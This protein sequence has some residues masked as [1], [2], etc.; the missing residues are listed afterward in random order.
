M[1]VRLLFPLTRTS[2]RVPFDNQCFSLSADSQ[3]GETDCW[4]LD[5]P[6][7]TCQNAVQEPG[8]C[9]PRCVEANPCSNPLLLQAGGRDSSRD[10]CMYM[11]ALY[12]HGDSWVLESD[13]CTSCECKVSWK[14][15][16]IACGDLRVLKIDRAQ[17]ASCGVAC[18]DLRV[19]KIGG[20]PIA[21]CGVACGD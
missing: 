7:L 3:H 18:G 5:C 21:S 4:P 12:G 8:D 11:G 9:C 2:L 1:R 19:L 6:Q 14:L 20:A 16:S 17:V 13:P 10:T 15:W